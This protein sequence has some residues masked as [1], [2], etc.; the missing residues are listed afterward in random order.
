MTRIN[1]ASGPWA[2]NCRAPELR[3][4]TVESPLALK[5]ETARIKHVSEEATSDPGAQDGLE[6]KVLTWDPQTD[7]KYSTAPAVLRHSSSESHAYTHFVQ[8]RGMYYTLKKQ[9]FEKDLKNLFAKVQ[10]KKQHLRKSRP[11]QPKAVTT[12]RRRLDVTS[13]AH[14]KHLRSLDPRR[15]GLH[16]GTQPCPV[17]SSKEQ[18]CEHRTQNSE[19]EPRSAPDAGVP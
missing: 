6:Q 4:A 3:A 10:R 18:Q 13:V 17:P 2:A 15:K 5:Q 16:C 9:T 12:A 11:E 7:F 19:T 14:E 1:G 8:E